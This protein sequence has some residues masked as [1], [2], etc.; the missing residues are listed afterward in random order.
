MRAE[1]PSMTSTIC[2]SCRSGLGPGG[3]RR[4]S[5]ALIAAR[6]SCTSPTVNASG[7][8]FFRCSRQT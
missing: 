6:I 8:I 1:V 2:P 7:V 3:I 4:D 5:H